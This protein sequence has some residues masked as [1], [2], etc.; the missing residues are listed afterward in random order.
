MAKYDLP[1]IRFHEDNV[2]FREAVNFTAAHTGFAERLIEKDYFC[3]LVLAHLMPVSGGQ[4]VF[5]G[6]TCLAKVLIDF[7]RLSEDLDFTIPLPVDASRAKR[8]K[9]AAGMKTAVDS[10]AKMLSGFQFV[11]P[12]RGANNSTQYVGAIGYTS[13]ITGQAETIQ[14]EVS[15]RE[16][17]L[18]P[19]LQG[20][21]RTVLLDPITDDAMV[22]E[23]TLPCISKI[24]ALAE[25]FRAAMTRRE[26][27]I[28]DF[29]DIDHAVR[30]LGVN[31]R[32]GD[33][34]RLVR[35]KLAVPGNDPLDVS[36]ARRQELA[37]QLLPRLRPVLRQRDFDA[38]D[39]DRAFQIV[40]E[41]AEMVT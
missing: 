13:P 19:I 31:V 2:L 36:L 28:R 8:S 18:T 29:Y 35:Q 11:Q 5:K 15:L 33:L 23:V 1:P 3:T 30:I 14:I 40:A 6:G 4:V 20:I 22:P 37:G 39:L 10:V 16:P 7:Y 9:C 21:A 41:M 24:E 25:K 12:M 38:F 34:S 27:A 32:R 26:V 17:L